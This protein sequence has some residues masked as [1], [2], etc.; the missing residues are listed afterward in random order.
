M[1]KLTHFK[2]SFFPMCTNNCVNM[3]LN[4][5]LKEMTS[6]SDITIGAGNSN[7]VSGFI[8]CKKRKSDVSLSA[9]CFDRQ[10][11]Q[12]EKVKLWRDVRPKT[13]YLISR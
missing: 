6:S 4:S 11:K 9:R 1:L 2:S 8:S 12:Q 7:A 3:M 10:Q 13:T 5:P